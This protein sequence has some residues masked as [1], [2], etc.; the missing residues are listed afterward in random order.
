MVLR[1]IYQSK[2]IKMKY[3]VY[4]GLLFL[5]VVSCKSESKKTPTKQ[6]EENKITSLSVP[7]VLNASLPRLYSNSDKLFLS[8][9]ENQDTL[10]VLKYAS[11]SGTSWS[12]PQIITS[13]SNWF[14]NWADFPSITENSGNILAHTLQKSASGTYTYDVKLSV[15]NAKTNS[16]KKDFLLN[17]DGTQSEHGFVS[18]VPYGENDFFAT[19]LDGRTTVNVPRDKAQMTIRSAIITA[20]GEILEDVLLDNR[21]CDCC[22]TATTMT[23]N[24]QLVVYRD[25]S[26]D[27]IRD[28]YVVRKVNEKWTKPQ[29][30][31][32]DNWHIPGCPVNGPAIAALENNVAVVWF[33]AANDD[34]KVQVAFSDDGGATFGLPVRVDKGNAIGRVDLVMLDKNN[35]AVLW[36][37]PQ[38]NDTVIQLAKVSSSGSVSTPI[39]ITK[40]ESSR[41]SGF[42]QLE[43]VKNTLYV[44]W[45]SLEEIQPTVK[46]VYL[47]I[48]SF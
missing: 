41:A 40:T 24:G 35:A 1:Y 22:N 9:V 16:W 8:W 37:E 17:L 31:Y 25:R 7:S 4:S 43:K 28:I 42:P 36:M 48:S 3:A 13:G 33:T 18:L 14:V 12:K 11:F 39:T 10:S 19:W 44:A 32:N 21:T 26:E 30:I 38:G 2:I 20:N 45:T 23:K 27:E 29:P 46:M 34:P 5:F 47:K 6:K 15:Y